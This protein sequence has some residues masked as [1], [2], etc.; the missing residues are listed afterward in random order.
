[1][2]IP[3]IWENKTVPNHQPVLFFFSNSSVG[4]PELRMFFAREAS[5]ERNYLVES[6]F[7][8]PVLCIMKII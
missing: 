5:L 4:I 7:T 3:N 1:M 8:T 6:V 2:I